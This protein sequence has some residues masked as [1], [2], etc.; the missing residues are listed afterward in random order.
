LDGAE[1]DSY[2]ADLAKIDTYKD[3]KISMAEFSAASKSG[4][5]K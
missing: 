5:V 3:G 2:K 4:L 1:L